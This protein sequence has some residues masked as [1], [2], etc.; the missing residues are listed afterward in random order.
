MKKTIGGRIAEARTAAGLNQS[1]LAAKIGVTPQSIQHWENDRT[2]PRGNRIEELAKTLEVTPEWLT[3]GSSTAPEGASGEII[4]SYEV[5]SYAAQIPLLD[6]ELAAG[7][8]TY[9]N[10]EVA[11]EH[12]TVGKEIFVQHGIAE[13]QVVA[14]RVKGESMSPRL[15]DGDTILVDTSDKIPKDQQVYAIAVE[16]DLKVK[17]L[18]RR[19]DGNWLIR[20]DN[21]DFADYDEV[22]SPVNFQNLRVIGRVFMIMMGEI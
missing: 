2:A 14:V 8:G 6:I 13:E 16:E 11:T 20:S 19:M 12:V 9:A 1:Q 7:A 21:R 15:H 5:S 22:I 3:F 10:M 4:H 18:V 17:R